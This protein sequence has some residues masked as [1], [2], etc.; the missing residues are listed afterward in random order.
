MAKQLSIEEVLAGVDCPCALLKHSDYL[1]PPELIKVRRSFV[2][3]VDNKSYREIPK[4]N[5][6]LSS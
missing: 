1:A 6:N 5:L 2:G 3:P 4:P